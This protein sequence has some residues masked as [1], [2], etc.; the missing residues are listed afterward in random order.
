MAALSKPEGLAL[1]LGYCVTMVVVA[2]VVSRRRAAGREEFFLAGRNV[3]WFVTALS[4]AA[5][6]IWAPALFVSSQKAYTHGLAGMFAFCVP[7]FFALILFGVV[8]KRIRAQIPQGT[9][10]PDYVRER[11]GPKVH[12]LYLV[13]FV[14]LQICSFAIQVLAGSAL[15]HFMTGMNQTVVALAIVATALVYSLFG[16]F[17]ASVVTDVLQIVL[18]VGVTAAAAGFVLASVGWDTLRQG[19]GGATG[20]YANPLSPWV[21]Y[22]FGIPAAIG[23]LSGPLGDQM[24]WQRAFALRKPGNMMRAYVVGAIVF[25]LVPLFLSLIGLVGAGS[26]LEVPSA[27][28]VGPQVV[29][30]TLPKAML[31]LFAVML[32]CG[33]GST[34]DSVLCAASVLTSVDLVRDRVAPVVAARI[35]MAVV[36]GIGMLLALIPGIQIVHLWLFAGTLRA[37]TFV[38]TI[39]MAFSSGLTANAVRRAVLWSLVCGGPVYAAGE[40]LKNPHLAVAGC[41]SVVVIGAWFVVSRGR[42]VYHVSSNAGIPSESDEPA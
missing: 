1:L 4:S 31:V 42:G 29:A 35:G 2:A 36:A 17:R 22:S 38:P 13:Q 11:F 24:H 33:L 7:N 37:A 32:L 14:G 25:I 27:Q 9:T 26:S 21:L 23:L 18:I 41:L 28:M 30:A 3:G 10:L 40:L 19:F 15:I 6:W 39:G 20:E 12:R 16:G 8:A 5:T 34:L